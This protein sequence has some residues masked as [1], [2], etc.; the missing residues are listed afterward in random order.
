MSTSAISR[1]PS[2]R[3]PSSRTAEMPIGDGRAGALVAKTPRFRVPKNGVTNSLA[4]SLKRLRMGG[5]PVEPGM[6]IRTRSW[7]LPRHPAR[8]L[9]I[10]S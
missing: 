7:S 8:G 5:N 1:I 2:S 4:D 3:T 6:A 10:G 9:R